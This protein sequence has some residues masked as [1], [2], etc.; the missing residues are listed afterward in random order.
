MSLGPQETRF[1]SSSKQPYEIMM[2]FDEPALRCRTLFLFARQQRI[3]THTLMLYS[4]LS[5]PLHPRLCEYPVCVYW[6]HSA[7]YSIRLVG[8]CYYR[9]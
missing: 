6:G 4:I 8:Y 7:A 9:A 2:A 1:H 3:H 5:P